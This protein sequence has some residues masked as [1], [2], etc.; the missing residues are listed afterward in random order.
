MES[1]QRPRPLS[2]REREAGGEQAAGSAAVWPS[3]Q[4]RCLSPGLLAFVSD[5]SSFSLRDGDACC[6]PAESPVGPV[7]QE[8]KMEEAV[9]GV[10][11]RRRP[12]RPG[13]EVGAFRAG[14]SDERAGDTGMHQ[15]P[16]G[17]LRNIRGTRLETHFT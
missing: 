8:E 14:H 4:A 16:L 12:G 1:E 9:P 10:R 2:P 7:S 6:V 3:P 5:S 17:P 15:L 11:R 13:C